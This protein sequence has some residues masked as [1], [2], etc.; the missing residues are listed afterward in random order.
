MSK[1]PKTAV[2][3]KRG[4]NHVRTLVEDAGS[5]FIKIEQENDLG[6]DALI[7]LIQ[8]GLP[9]N[10]QVAVQI[11]SGQ[12]Y[13]DSESNECRFPIDTHRDYWG[14]HPLPVIG[15]VFVPSHKT[16]YWVDLKEFLN[17]HPK[18]TTVRFGVSEINK[19]DEDSFERIFL[20]AISGKVPF[21]PLERALQ[22]VRSPNVDEA[23]LAVVVL[24]R[25]FPNDTRTW[26]ELVHFFT[27][28]PLENIPGQLIYYMAH[29]PG[30][31]DIWWTG[32][33]LSS[34]T[35]AY[36]D[37]LF[38]HFGH[39]EVLKLLAMID[40]EGS[41]A[42]GSV[43]QSVEALISSLPD[44]SALL[45]RAIADTEAPI[46][47]RECAALILAM[48]EAKGALQD[49]GLLAAEGSWTAA[50]YIRHLHEFGEINPY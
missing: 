22:L 32:E 42:R 35:R 16:A 37:K 29:V 38:S 21:L 1:Y 36:A 31:P 47:S 23:L 41:I 13:F 27:S 30:H 3:A 4:V 5:L 24:F 7:E 39:N 10:R 12:S 20:P 6:I 28:R 43:G 44:R 18:A 2:T 45:R 26:D 8:G 49:L 11:K 14:K 17:A 19:L 33:G 25:R 15:I 50:E 40:P 34:S 9:L 46:F 48:N